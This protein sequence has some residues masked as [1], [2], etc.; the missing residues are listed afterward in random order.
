M[1]L[2]LVE[3]EGA[4]PVHHRNVSSVQEMLD[5]IGEVLEEVDQQVR[6]SPVQHWLHEVGPEVL[7][8]PIKEGERYAAWQ[9]WHRSGG[10]M[11]D[12]VVG[13]VTRQHFK[14]MIRSTLLSELKALADLYPGVWRVCAVDVA[15]AYKPVWGRRSTGVT[16]AA[17]QVVTDAMAIAEQPNPQQ[18]VP[19]L[20]KK[21]RI[22]LN[23]AIIEVTQAPPH[24]PL[25]NDRESGRNNTGAMYMYARTEGMLKHLSVKHAGSRD[26]AKALIAKYGA[27]HLPDL[28]NPKPKGA[29]KGAATKPKGAKND[30]AT[31]K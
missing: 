28:W 12:G 17:S 19:V 3:T 23:M 26:A 21:R 14:G 2:R 10:F 15:E 20:V 22:R 29:K 25:Y 31:T 5:C 4:V 9:F 30:D 8:E 13:Q 1:D 11:V 7:V 6:A 18:T 27:K 16:G 24:D